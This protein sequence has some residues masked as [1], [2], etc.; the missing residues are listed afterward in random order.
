MNKNFDDVIFVIQNLDLPDEQKEAIIEKL[1][2][3]KAQVA[4]M[5]APTT[6]QYGIDPNKPFDIPGVYWTVT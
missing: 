1:R 6:M 3:M 5:I 2:A 4:I